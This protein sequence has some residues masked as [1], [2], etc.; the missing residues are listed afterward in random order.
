MQRSMQTW[1][2]NMP[3]TV[4]ELTTD[5]LVETGQQMGTATPAAEEKKDLATMRTELA[6][7]MRLD[8][9]TRAEGFDD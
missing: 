1:S 6:M 4:N 7:I 3:V 2:K 5:V 9:R 8:L